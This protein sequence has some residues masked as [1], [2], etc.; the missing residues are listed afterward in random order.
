[1][2]TYEARPRNK[3]CELKVFSR[4]RVVAAASA[5]LVL[6]SAVAAWVYTKRADT[7]LSRSGKW[8]CERRRLHRLPRGS[9]SGIPENRHG[10]VVRPSAAGTMFP[11]SESLS[12]TRHR[13]VTSPWSRATAGTISG[14]GRS[15]SMARRRMSTRNKS[16]SLSAREIIRV[17]YL[18]LTSRGML[19]V[20]PLSWYAEKGG[21]W[22]MSPGYDQPDFPGSVRP[23]HYE[24]MFCHNAYPKIPDALEHTANAEMTFLNPLPEGIDCQ[25]C[26]G[27][28]QRHVALASAGHNGTKPGANSGRHR[29]P[30]APGAPDRELEVCMQ[31]HLET[32]SLDLPHAIRRFDR[33]PFSY[34][35]G[36]PLGDFS[37]EFDRPGGMK[38]SGLQDRFEIAQGAYRLRRSQ[39]FIQSA[40]KLRC[41]TCHD[42]HNIPRGQAAA[43]H[44]NAVCEQCHAAN[45]RSGR[46]P[47]HIPPEP[48]ASPATCRSAEPTMWCM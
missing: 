48:I 8:L 14:A 23:V 3:G 31:C 46:P 13:T 38:T 41:T 35:P 25:R 7:L 37:V 26:H 5:A 21:Y 9:R 19:Q 20:L 22:D 29:Q 28:G 17:T 47:G 39:C 4:R 42:P 45:A 15:G 6:G 24:C 12:I 43:T 18:H 16:I 44:Y 34:V 2:M 11:N 32:T 30:E 10:T 33:A 36:Q 27:P 1:M 40:G